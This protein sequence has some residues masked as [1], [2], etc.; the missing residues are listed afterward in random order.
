MT[1]NQLSLVSS[2]YNQKVIDP[3]DDTLNWIKR[4]KCLSSLSIEYNLFS[5]NY[6]NVHALYIFLLRIGLPFD[7]FDF[8]Y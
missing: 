3:V 7:P 6:Y 1:V 2:S 4:D 5:K 8:I